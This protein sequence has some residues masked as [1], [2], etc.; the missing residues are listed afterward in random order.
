MNITQGVPLMLRRA[1]QA[2]ES[3]IRRA[4][5]QWREGLVACFAVAA[6]VLVV[7]LA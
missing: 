2:A 1:K 7:V 6:V 5:T 3:D 4:R